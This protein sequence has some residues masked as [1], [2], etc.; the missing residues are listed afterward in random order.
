VGEDTSICKHSNSTAI[1]SVTNKKNE[2][3]STAVVSNYSLGSN[4]LDHEKA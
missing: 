4:R 2:L 1:L 3:V